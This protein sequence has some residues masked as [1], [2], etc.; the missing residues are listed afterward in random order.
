[1]KETG[2][3]DRIC[4]L[5]QH[6]KENIRKQEI[7]MRDSIYREMQKIHA[8]ESVEKQFAYGFKSFLERKPVLIQKEDLLAGFAYHYSYNST[9]PADGPEDFDPAVKSVFHMDME[10]EIQDTREVLNLKAGDPLENQ[11]YTFKEGVEC[12]LYKHWHSGHCLAGYGRLLEKGFGGLLEDEQKKY[13]DGSCS[14]DTREAFSIVTSACISYIERYGNLAENMELLAETVEQRNRMKR[15]KECCR[16][17]AK[18]KPE[19][20]FDALQLTWFAHELALCESYPSAVSFGR[21]DFYLFPFYKKDRDAGR[22]TRKE[23]LELI[24]AFWIKCSTSVKGY[25]NLM[26]GGTDE[27]GRCSVNDLTYLCMEASE[28]LKFD[29]PSLSFRWTEDMPKEA[30]HAV[31][32]LIKT[33][34]G[35][36]ALFGEKYCREA[37]KRAGIKEKDLYQFAAVGCV[38]LNIPGKEYALTEIA[39]LNLPKVLELMLHEG[40]DPISGKQFSLHTAK[41]AEDLDHIHSFEEF[42][43]WYLKEMEHFI[44]LG[45]ECVNAFDKMYGEKYPLPY[46]STMTEGC[47]EKGKDISAG[48]AIYNGSGFNAGGVATTIDSLLAVKKVVFEWKRLSLSA[49]VKVLDADYQGHEDLRLLVSNQCPKFGNDIDE[50][51]VLGVDLVEKFINIVEEYET[52]RGGKYRAGLYTVEDHAIMGSFTGATPDGRRKGKALSNSFSPSQGK[53]TKGPTALMNT[54]TKFPLY[55]A[56]NGMVLD[57]KFTPSFLEKDNHIKAVTDLLSTYFSQGGMEA[58]LSVVS[59]DTL[60]QAQKHPEDYQDLVVRV[61]GFSAYFTSLRKVTQDEIISRTE[62]S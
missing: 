61:S 53:D 15:I 24:E 43:Q 48:G 14:K 13:V 12:W 3:S 60:L 54:V 21:F 52:P 18:G 37:K 40:K 41:K 27:K 29:Q 44:R 25:Q 7:P 58:Q 45:I 36:P 26:L 39:R 28:Y 38:E 17:I 59:R 2:L 6:R 32:R 62:V 50:M 22:I 11:L 1:M 4:Y 16:R 46:L 20:F 57:L 5:K 30:L 33:G 34:M 49:F 56:G 9:F 23:A 42:Y 55:K 47:I 51:D 19:S 31:L 35:F 10:R 8:A